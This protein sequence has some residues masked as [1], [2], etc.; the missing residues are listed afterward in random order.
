MSI[1][2]R[3]YQHACAESITEQ[4]RTHQSTLLCLFT[5]GG[6]T[7]IFAE[8]I[9]R[10]RPGRAVVICNREELLFQACDKIHRTTGLHCEIEMADNF[11]AHSLFNSA[12]VIVSTVQTQI[13]GRKQKRMERF[14]PADFS[15]LVVDEAHYSTSSSFRQCIEY[16]QRNPNLK[17]LGVTATPNRHDQESLGQIYTSVA[18]NYGMREGIYLGWLCDITQLFIP[19][20]GLDYSHIRTTSKGDLNEAELASVMEE[21]ENIVGICQPSLEVMFALRPQTLSAI[22]VPEWG[23]Y[24]RG[25]NRPGRKTIVFTASVAH[26]DLCAEI[27]NRVIPEMAEA[28]N[29]ETPKDKRRAL[30]KR[31]AAG[32]VRAVMNCGILTTGFDDP[33]VEVIVMARPTKSKLLYEQMV[34]RST[35]PLPGTVDGENLDTP[36]KRLAAI[37]GSAKPFCRIV[38][39][40]GNSGKHKLI[41]T[42]DV[43]GG[44]ISDEAK[45]KAIKKM[46]E[47]GKPV[48]VSRA[49][50]QAEIDLQ[51]EQ[52]DERDRLKRMEAGRRNNIVAKVKFS[53]QSINPFDALGITP[54]SPYARNYN[55]PPSEKMRMIL[56]KRG[57]NCEKH[58][59]T[60]SDAGRMIG[61]IAKKEGWGKR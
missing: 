38:D 56:S 31:F 27:F 32:D 36:T 50:E 10:M 1:N 57:I 39:F 20:A 49:L 18:A 14:N 11:A 22:P 55:R 4:W 25:L 24:I 15:L 6:K 23:D 19:V 53:V 17:V 8:M 12:D 5:G 34:G 33:S 35:R 46:Q 42:I 44:K 28:V 13:S 2:L 60:W 41:T 58:N 61:A 26:A 54:A 47:D 59:I 7:I 45:A 16:Y 48:K 51:A 30:L 9:R 29:G 40:V 37:A 52:Q 3:D 43:L 21:Q